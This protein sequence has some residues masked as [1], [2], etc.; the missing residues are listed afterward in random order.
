MRPVRPMRRMVG[1]NIATS[2]PSQEKQVLFAF[3]LIYE[4]FYNRI[5]QHFLA[6]NP[7]C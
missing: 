3:S 2:W 7:W 1:V 4:A 6:G 5:Q